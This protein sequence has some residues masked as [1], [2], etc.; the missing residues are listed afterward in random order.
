MECTEPVIQR[1][2]S[3]LHRAAA[4]SGPAQIEVTGLTLTAG[5]V[6]ACAVALDEQADLFLDRLAFELGPDAWF[7]Q[8]HGRRDIWYLNLLHFTTDIPSPTR[9]INWITTHRNTLVGRT[10]I[11]TAELV[12]FHHVP[13]APRPFMRPEVLDQAVLRGS[14][15]AHQTR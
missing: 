13:T 9:L 3:A 8:P 12:R 2:Q 4:Q 5:T 7:E 14:R 10:T 15:A 11:P 6:M 1:Y